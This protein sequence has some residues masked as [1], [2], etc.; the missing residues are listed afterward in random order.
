MKAL[1]SATGSKG[2]ALPTGYPGLC[3]LYLPRPIRQESE[4]DNAI[5]IVDALAGHELNP[6]QEDYLE[7]V[8]TF[9]E[10]YERSTR[11]PRKTRTGVSLLKFLLDQHEM[12]AADLSRLLGGSR[13]LGAMILRGERRLTVAHIRRVSEHFGVP[14]DLL[15]GR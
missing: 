1:I 14:A 2:Q 8:S 11:K 12:T 15:I 3:R 4:L 13:G 10:Q 7:A 9:I 5:E 6:E